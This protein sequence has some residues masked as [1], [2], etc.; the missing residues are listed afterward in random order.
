MSNE[1]SISTKLPFN[2]DTM[3]QRL[4]GKKETG[5]IIKH[6]PSNNLKKSEDDSTDNQPQVIEEKMAEEEE[7]INENVSEIF[8]IKPIHAAKAKN[9]LGTRNLDRTLIQERLKKQKIWGVNRMLLS[10]SATVEDK[11]ISKTIQENETKLVEKELEVIEKQNEFEKKEDLVT[12]E[13]VVKPAIGKK[14]KIKLKG[15]VEIAKDVIIQEPENI[16]KEN[17]E[18]E[19]KEEKN[20]K[21][22]KEQEF[23]EDEIKKSEKENT[24][25]IIKI[26]KPR[27]QYTKRIIQG[28]HRMGG[29]LTDE[30]IQMRLPNK[31]DK[32]VIRASPYYMTNRKLFV[33]H[34]NRLF[35]PYRKELLEDAGTI[36]CDDRAKNIDF[37][38]L[39]HQLVVK[40]YLNLYTPYRGL[41]LY[42]GLG[43]GKSCSSIGI[44]EGM[45][46][47]KSVMLMTP[48]SLKSNFF[49]E[50]KKCGD[51]LFR[52]NQFWEWISI[53]GNPAYKSLLSKSLGIPA[54]V[55]EKNHGAWMVDVK[56]PA[57]FAQ[58]STEDQF[59][60][61]EQLD[62][63]IR[64]KYT[65]INY[66]GFNQRVMNEITENNTI[67]PFDH[68]VVIIDE[69][70]NFI[71][72]IVNK[73]DKPNSLSSR[74][75]HYLMDA[76]DVRIVLLSGTPIINYPNE[77]SVLFNILRGYIKTWTIPIRVTTNE[78]V[79]RDAILDLFYKNGFRTYDYVEYSGNILTITRNPFGFVNM[80]SSKA[81]TI[82]KST[83][84]KSKKVIGGGGNNNHHSKL[85]KQKS[86]KIT[87]KNK[88]KKKSRNQKNMD[89]ITS[90]A[91]EKMSSGL[92]RV[93]PI[94]EM[95]LEKE[96]TDEYG[97][98]EIQRELYK[99][100]A[101][102]DT[103]EVFDH[104]NGVKL[105]ETGNIS[106]N[107]FIHTVLQILN[108]NGLITRGDPTM[109]R[110]KLLPDNKDTF[111][112]TFIED[113]TGNVKNVKVFK[114]RVLG[115]TSYFRSAQE[116][117][118]PSFILTADGSNYHRVIVPMSEYQFGVYNKIRMIE[119]DQ[120]TKQKKRKARANNGVSELYEISSTYRVFSRTACNFVFPAEQPR[121]L[122]DQKYG[123]KTEGEK[124]DEPLSEEVVDIVPKSVRKTADDYMEDEE[125]ADVDDG[126]EKNKHYQERIDAA[127]DFLKYD[128]DHPR[129]E[130]FVTLE[131]LETYGPKFARIL[132]NIVDPKH[133]GLHLLYSQF[134]TIEGI[135]IMRL[136][137]MA[138]GF[139]EF[140]LQRNGIEWNMVFSEEDLDKPLFV[141][142]TGTETTEEKEVVLK[143]YNGLWDDVPSNIVAQLNARLEHI[144]R[145]NPEREYPVDKNIYGDIIKV[146]MITS[147]G[148]EGINLANT[149]YVH[150]MEPY[151]N[152]VRMEQVIGRARRICSHRELPEDLRT[153]EVFL[154]I[155]TLT[156]GQKTDKN[157][158]ELRINDVSRLDHET[159]VTTDETLY[160][161]SV[162]K[163]E[164]N[165]Q[166]LTAMKETSIDCSLYSSK[167]TE[168]L[169]CYNY[170]KVETN[171]FN[172]YPTLEQDTI[173]KS[174]ND[175]KQITW[176]AKRL[177][178]NDVEYA[179]NPE[180]YEVYDMASYKQ[181]AK[182]RGPLVLVG[183]YNRAT[184]RIE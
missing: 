184:K 72:R 86:K 81:H 36:T 183:T 37:G 17:V 27:K 49:A 79:N 155:S 107:D 129:P 75:Y 35:A 168:P 151:W 175:T 126:E 21:E 82:S 146:I 30:T 147:S 161:I 99:G 19:E 169:V 54:D 152:M 70:H 78:R 123:K 64:Q 118:L 134:R 149:R 145:K 8:S 50:L 20:D 141:L 83:L 127:L 88:S 176:K 66:N 24:E 137:L 85:S 7:P 157:N 136:V 108:R 39:T 178:I 110:N 77:I 104:Y 148:S 143:I 87:P 10:K 121:P 84:V 22:M 153:V 58:L 80:E 11:I 71:S 181:A 29:I 94:S 160:E 109:V 44:A 89:D 95:D 93:K 3:K 67:N 138:A 48:K 92:I 69:A 125:D 177:V 52:K 68:K 174:D 56:K 74:L 40:T 4:I 119:R 15:T 33:D 76:T 90:E 128:P 2:L 163:N 115:L 38:L 182:A 170:G 120:E 159:P 57:N 55:I 162:I 28:E 46:T 117:L 133:V 53:D 1:T 103:S 165:Q 135:G 91:Y 16:P 172:S 100:G 164:T 97:K 47:Q 105:D 122:P 167:S 171:Q 60:I 25:N 111:F 180:T 140:K 156:E 166:I 6:N 12:E 113:E 102:G 179:L 96:E 116:Q 144:R 23:K 26:K 18:K 101:I 14:R 41:L 139:A 65:D 63:M 45:K 112:K 73:L 142:Y 98:D 132:E 124:E 62:I 154:Y 32:M 42:H 130:E 51:H 43:S 173:E 158:I 150:I 106:D 13:V 34:I 61:D 5:I 59:K 9:L 31:G 131:G 114:N